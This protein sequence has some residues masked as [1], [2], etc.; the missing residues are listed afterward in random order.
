MS[1]LLDDT[2]VQ[3]PVKDISQPLR[4]AQDV[5]NARVRVD[6]SRVSRKE[7]EDNFLQLHDESLLLKQHIHQQE[8]KIR[9]LGT[10]LLRLVKDRRRM[11]QLAGGGGAPMVPRR[12]DAEKEDLVDEFKEK[13]RA[14]ETDNDKL[15]QRLFVAKQQQQLI[16]LSPAARSSHTR[17]Q[18][19][20][21]SAPRKPD[22]ASSPSPTPPRRARSAAGDERPPSG[23]PTAYLHAL[24]EEAREK[25]RNLENVIESQQRRIAQLE[26]EKNVTLQQQNKS[27]LRSQI[28]NNV[29]MIKLQKQLAERCNAMVEL[30]ERFLQ[31]QESQH[32]QKACYDA[33]TAKMAELTS[34]LRD[35]RAKSVE[36]R[37]QLQT[38]QLSHAKMRQLEERVDEVE[39]EKEL[40]KEHN[41]K[42]LNSMLDG[43]QQQR[44]SVQE[45]QL[46]QHIAQLEQ[47]LQGDLQ[48]K[49][50]ILEE[51]KAERD[52]CENLTEENRKLVHQLAEKKREIE[53]LQRR[54]DAY[55]RTDDYDGE[56][57][58]EALL[59]IKA[60]K[61][62][63]SG[64]LGFLQEGQDGGMREHA[65]AHVETIHELEKVRQ[66]LAVESRISSDLKVEL[67]SVQ[68][69]MECDKRSHT[70]QLEHQA[71][72][73]AAKDAKMHKLEAQLRDV[74]Y[75]AKSVSAQDRDQ[76]PALEDGE[77]L[78]ELQ[79]IG[80]TLS[81]AA[82]EAL[83]DP[84]PSTFCTYAFYLFDLHATPVATGPT[85]HYGFTSQY[86][87]SVDRGFLEYVRERRLCVEMH[88]ALGLRWKTMATAALDLRR[89]LRDGA[90]AGTLPLV[91]NYGEDT[92]FGSLEYWI[93]LRNPIAESDRLVVVGS[94]DEQMAAGV[95]KELLVEV[96]GCSGLQSRCSSLPSPYVVYK[97][98]HFPDY[99]TSTVHDCCQPR[100]A[101]MK[102]F[103][104]ADDG[105]LEHYLAS[106]ALN[107]Y[108]FDYKE[109]QMDEY[110]GK[111]AV[112]LAALLQD[113]EIA[114]TFD[115][116]D[117]SGRHV[118]HID[119]AIK[120]KLPVV[121]SGKVLPPSQK[122]AEAG[123]GRSLSKRHAEP[124]KLTGGGGEQVFDAKVAT[125]APTLTP[126]KKPP[127]KDEQVA[128]RV[129]FQEAQPTNLELVPSRPIHLAE[130]DEDDEE[131]S[132]SEGQLLLPPPTLT[133][134][135]CDPQ[136]PL[137]PTGG[138]AAESA[139]RRNAS[140]WSQSDSDDDDGIVHRLATQGLQRVRVEVA[141]LSLEAESRL[142][143]DVS[144]VRLFVEF[145]FLDMPTEETPVSLPKPPPGKSVSFNFSK[146][147]AVDA[148]SSASRRKLLK[149]VLQGRNPDMERI[150][151]TVVSE[152][153][154]EEEQERECEDV[155]VAFLAIPDLLSQPDDVAHLDLRV[156]DTEDGVSQLGSL[157]VS[158]EGVQ[159]LRA[160]LEESDGE[161]SVAPSSSR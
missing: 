130:E 139:S 113:Q 147:I 59:L 73:M 35:E 156:V 136:Q 65:D 42:L 82:L 143:R 51:V 21:A 150:R 36:L 31:L 5:H 129:T 66:L 13:V 19:R 89:L 81:A 33:A 117:S 119:L 7:L 25:S 58:T 54:V 94:H 104:L 149:E 43:S 154:E 157:R 77:N 72:M 61:S 90:A 47:A 40:L 132:I 2:A 121:Q 63:Q 9:K 133:S 71:Q 32:T 141:C 87:V 99:P 120:W 1:F 24:L 160:I 56:K 22:D 155:G 137:P 91:G 122:S 146:V 96:R 108:V 53:E 48:D 114:G 10:K 138:G 103:R 39:Q 118:G 116:H 101:D 78:V 140:E 76:S 93:K 45:R 97:L 50:K 16:A 86:V 34:Q 110:L 6:V 75:G 4:A 74:A 100:F 15:R 44:W 49:K 123:G 161:L 158:F 153:P 57:L 30:E 12:W 60:Q 28:N 151:F 112:P 115:L 84:A 17:V 38:E 111:A 80:A 88:Q 52:A 62:Q 67:D 144:V 107:L 125:L 55:S 128:K 124:S 102:S 68:K 41:E 3:E 23:Q 98:F 29:T 148:A 20:A 134:D 11:E 142:C 95:E 85:P 18:T 131:S 14:L 126:A 92:S 69:K 109:P 127:S 145:S 79:I 152:P 46:Q 26:E 37:T 70:Q 64:E 105:A 83:G 8:D 135:L 106:E 159:T 27:E